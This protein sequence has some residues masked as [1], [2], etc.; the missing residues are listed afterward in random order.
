MKMA[1]MPANRPP[2]STEIQNGVSRSEK[3]QMMGSRIHMISFC[4]GGRMQSAET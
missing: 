2:P 1:K 4:A 3:G